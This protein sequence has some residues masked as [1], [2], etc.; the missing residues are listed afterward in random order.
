M[1]VLKQRV[2]TA[3][4]VCVLLLCVSG[5]ARGHSRDSDV[6]ASLQ[7][8][9]FSKILTFDRTLVQRAG[10]RIDVIVLYQDGNITSRDAAEQLVAAFRKAG[11]NSI[12]N[13]PIRFKLIAFEDIETVPAVLKEHAADVVYVAPV[14]AVRVE[15]L[16]RAAG[17]VAPVLA[18]SREY[19][20]KGAAIGLELRNSKPHILVN[21][22]AAREQGMEL[23][24][25]LLKLAEVVK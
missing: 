12:G 14:R 23:S 15:L 16:L 17:R 13:Q 24:S 22:D 19:V 6:P 18:G 3:L 11:V 10:E 25:Q 2:C 1:A 4:F 8:L 20:A 5:F 7:A 9:L 21:L